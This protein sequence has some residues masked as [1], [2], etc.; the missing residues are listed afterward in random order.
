M[1]MMS[2]RRFK[3]Q[4]KKEKQKSEKYKCNQICS[5]NQNKIIRIKDSYNTIINKVYTINHFYKKKR[6]KCWGLI[7]SR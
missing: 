3:K 6:T 7:L 4:E 2:K 5:I 1:M